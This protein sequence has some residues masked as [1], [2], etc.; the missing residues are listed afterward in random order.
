MPRSSRRWIA[1]EYGSYH[2]ISRVAGG[3]L[4]FGDDEKRYLVDLIER[5]SRGFYVK[6]HTF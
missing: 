1:Q 4:I 6:L 5:M 2:L 3:E